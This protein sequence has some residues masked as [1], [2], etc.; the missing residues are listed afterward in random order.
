LD[1]TG[2]TAALVKSLA[3]SAGKVD[4]TNDKIVI[5]DKTAAGGLTALRAAI[6]TAYAGGTWTGNGLTSAN[7]AADRA[8]NG[9]TAKTG[10][11]YLDNADPIAGN[12]TAFYGRSVNSNSLMARYTYYGDANLDGRVNLADFGILKGRYGTGSQWYHGDF[13]YNGVVNLADFGKLKAAYG[14]TPITAAAVPEPSVVALLL[15]GGLIAGFQ[16]LRRRRK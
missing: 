8:A 10:V 3:I 4:L 9:A 16:I 15:T 13:D 1:N 5:A 11:G 12:K 14:S 7:A 6:A 2:T